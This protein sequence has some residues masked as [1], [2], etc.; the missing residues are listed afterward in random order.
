MLSKLSNISLKCNTLPELSSISDLSVDTIRT[1]YHIAKLIIKYYTKIKTNN[2][3][4]LKLCY[5]IASII[6]TFVSFY[7]N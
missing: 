3:L 1:V 2:L 6:C 4:Q 5:V 7:E